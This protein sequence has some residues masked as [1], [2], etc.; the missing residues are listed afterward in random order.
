MFLLFS[1]F[2]ALLLIICYLSG[3]GADDGS[4]S[5]SEIPTVS[6]EVVE[7]S[8]EFEQEVGIRLRLNVDSAPTADIAV[9]VESLIWDA[10]PENN[11]AGYTWIIIP[12]FKES[13]EFRLDLNR[14]FTWDISILPLT[15]TNLNEYPIEGFDIPSNY[16]FQKYS[17]GRPSSVVTGPLS[18]AQLLSVWP[19]RGI[20]VPANTTFWLTF[21][22]VI[23]NITVSHGRVI[24]HGDVVEIV[25]TFPRGEL[26]LEISWDDGLGNDTVRRNIAEPDFEPP[27]LLRTFA[28]SPQGFGIGFNQNVLVPPD[29]ETIELIFNED[30]WVNEDIFG[31]IE[32]QTL[33]GD[34]MG[35]QQEF[36]LLNSNEIILV[37]S[38]GRPLHPGTTYV[39]VGTVTDL[40]NETEV[41]L[42]FTT[43]NR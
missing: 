1:R 37:R 4:G 13:T 17:V 5:I 10:A 22:S 2:I 9:L 16:K 14:Y 35:W 38:N 34:D 24:V 42:P 41:K 36:Q 32:I 23:E 40:A 43:S 31:D 30:I 3:C 18:G 27:K 39:I 15:G 12:K 28:F 29:T 20:F 8:P 7:L 21:D 33:A 26:R 25:G 11:E 19:D 6:I